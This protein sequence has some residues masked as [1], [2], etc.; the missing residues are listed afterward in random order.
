MKKTVKFMAGVLLCASLLSP[1]PA[2]AELIATGSSGENVLRIQQRLIDLHFYNFRPTGN[3]GSL[4]RM[5]A[6]NFQ[7]FNSIMADG[8]IGDESMGVLFSNAAKRNPIAAKIPIGPSADTNA[9]AYGSFSDWATEVDPAFALNDSAV[10]T[11]VV[12]GKQFSVVRTG[13]VNHAEVEPQT[14]EDAAKFLEIFGGEANWSK[15][16]VTVQLGAKRVAA[17]LQGMPHGADGLPGN[18]VTGGC[19]LYFYGSKSDV[20]G[21]TDVEHDEAVRRAA[22]Q[23]N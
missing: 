11:D 15:R 13:G 22:G 6:M 14:A 1:I 7:E 18:S 9:G 19:C 20:L 2:S 8:S 23:S 5:A 10:L 3:F 21:F 12:T 17:S 4:T 16:A